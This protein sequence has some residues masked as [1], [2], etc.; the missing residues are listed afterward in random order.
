MP[1]LA[2]I[3]AVSFLA[4]CGGGSPSG[5]SSAEG[6]TLSGT[7]LDASAFTIRS[8]SGVR[9]M[10][11]ADTITVTVQGTSI[12]TTVAPDGTFTLRGLPAGTI[13]L[14]FTSGG[15]TLGT[16]TIDS[17]AP[18]QQVT[19]TVLVSGGSVTVVD[20]QRNGIGHGDVEVEG[21]V[22]TI[23]SVNA[24]ADSRFTVNGKTVIA[25]A[26]QTAIR[27][28]NKSR[29]ATDIQVGQRV[30]V[31]GTYQA[32]EGTVTPVLA[33]EIILQGSSGGGGGET[34]GSGN[35]NASCIIEGG[36][37]GAGI[38]LEGT[39]SSGGS[40]HFVMNT[41]GNRGSN[42]SV[43]ASGASFQCNGGGPNAPTP[44]Q[45][46]ASVKS[47]AKVHVSGSLTSCST[48]AAAVDAR[49]V[50]VQGK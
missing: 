8:A 4:A 34:P 23:V 30:H 24:S 35:P 22:Q 43:D 27:V 15:T 38:E 48:T 50:K 39:V 46:K 11:A 14:V 7:V 31:K 33:S 20:E 47:G 32:A 19:V 36:R 6:V 21:T 28:G 37:V 10:S 45:C 44:D 40:T 9:T 13:T 12:S 5:P 1:L 42:I 49:S 26:G 25:R 41:N 29:S 2:V 17:V 18:N 3:A 16:A